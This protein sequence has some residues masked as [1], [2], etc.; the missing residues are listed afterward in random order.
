[1]ALANVDN[2]NVILGRAIHFITLLLAELGLV[3]TDFSTNLGF[4]PQP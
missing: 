3:P 2:Y 4:P 1:M